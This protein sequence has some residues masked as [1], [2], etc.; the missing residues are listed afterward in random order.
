M[1]HITPETLKEFIKLQFKEVLFKVFQWKDGLYEFVAEQIKL[2]PKLISPQKPEQLLLDGYRM[3][4]EWP[5]ILKKIASLDA[6]Y[7]PI[8]DAS[9]LPPITDKKFPEEVSIDEEI[10]QAFSEFEGSS[11]EYSLDKHG[12]QFSKEERNILSAIDGW[13]TVKEVIEVSRLGTFDTCYH[14]AALLDKNAIIKLDATAD[15]R[16]DPEALFQVDSTSKKQRIFRTAL[17]LIVIGVICALLPFS[18]LYFKSRVIS[19]PKTKDGFYL[20]VGTNPITNYIRLNKIEQI[21]FALE[22]YQL[23]NDTYPESLQDLITEKLTVP[24]AVMGDVYYKKTS[25][26][27]KILP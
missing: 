8:V 27:Y 3:L 17:D 25:N 13:K 21:K 16:V 10:D 6:I 18:V 5:A 24:D 15:S 9:N 11:H 20:N 14:M 22:L 12:E 4:D 7:K 26:K 2:N 23:K 1:K 19:S